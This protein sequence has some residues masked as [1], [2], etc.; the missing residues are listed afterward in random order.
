MLQ[1]NLSCYV[2]I[3]KMWSKIF[4]MVLTWT[5]VESRQM[6]LIKSGFGDGIGKI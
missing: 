6:D 1:T 3:Y 4:R 2:I 5:R